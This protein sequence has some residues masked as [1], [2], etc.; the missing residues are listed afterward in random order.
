MGTFT[1]E[2]R[3]CP[4]CADVGRD[5]SRDN[6]SVRDD[7]SGYCFACGRNYS[8]RDL[9]GDPMEST[10]KKSKL[11]P[12]DFD[13]LPFGGDPS[14]NIPDFLYREYAVRHSVD[15]YTGEPSKV[16]YPYF[17]SGDELSST[18]VGYKIRTLPKTFYAA[19]KL[20]GLFGAPLIPKHPKG[21][22]FI[23]EGEE[24]ALAVRAMLHALGKE[25]HV[26][27]SVPNGTS[28]SEQILENVSLISKFRK[29]YIIF[30]SDE[31]GVRAAQKTADKLVC[32]VPSLYVVRLKAFKD[33]SEYYTLGDIVQFWGE[34]LSAKEYTPEGIVAGSDTDLSELKEATPD[35]VELP[36][37]MLNSKLHGLRKGEI[38]LIT[39]AS[40]IGKTTIAREIGYHLVQSGHTVCHIALEDLMKTVKL[41]YIAMDN[42][43]PWPLLRSNPAHLP[44][45]KWEAS[46]EKILDRMYFFRHFGSLN[47][48]E[49]IRNIEYYVKVRNV[50][51]IILDHLSMVISGLDVSN[52]RK[53]I[54]MIMTEL[55]EIVVK[56]GVGLLPIVHL[57]RRETSGEK[58]LNEGGRVQLS[59]LRGSAALEQLSWAVLAAERDQ[60]AEDGSEDYLKLRLLKNRTW[61]YTG[62]CD[63][64]R[65]NHATGRLELKK[66]TVEELDTSL[67]SELASKEEA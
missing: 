25:D 28:S 54:D 59:D 67:K 14:R 57:K 1:G 31:P 37:P 58:S 48:R 20:S 24:D 36:W 19:G 10:P 41:S 40:G 11:S 52:E 18:P 50:D 32:E 8:A 49:L 47:P 2:K 23:T 56:T 44:D 35:G 33:A 26:A 53:A 60:Q 17:G 63:T 30:D 45:D 27:V 61:G 55:A 3:Q 22:L 62:E 66:L 21:A 65:Y 13:E 9:S 7:G 6:L 16:L 4:G 51:Y 39:G 34:I 29:V 46:K 15:E 43:V 12:E 64:L 38:T 42:N 5:T